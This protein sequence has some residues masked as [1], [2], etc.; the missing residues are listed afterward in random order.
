MDTHQS[1]INLILIFISLSIILPVSAGSVGAKN[2]VVTHDYVKATAICS[3]GENNY[4]SGNDNYIYHNA[5]FE[6]YCPR[7]HSYGTLKFNPKGVPEGEWTCSKCNSDYCAADGREKITG[8]HYSLTPYDPPQVQAQDEIS[9]Q[10]DVITDLNN[11]TNKSILESD[12]NRLKDM[13]FFSN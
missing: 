6:N 9:V 5:S 3:C 7:C 8:S 12:Y 10:V 13:N 2:V 11:A 1:F 4:S